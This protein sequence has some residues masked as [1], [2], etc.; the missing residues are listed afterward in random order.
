[1][2]KT[3]KG[4][5]LNFSKA[6]FFSPQG[7]LIRGI[8]ISLIFFILHLIGCKKYA[9]TLFRTTFS[10]VMTPIAYIWRLAGLLYGVFYFA[11]LLLAP[12]FFI[13][14]LFFL[15]FLHLEDRL[16]KTR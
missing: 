1:M 4:H 5:F 7:F 11:F 6:P 2:L 10:G 16:K 3:I 9:G 14:A 12:I 8:E 15:V 13:A